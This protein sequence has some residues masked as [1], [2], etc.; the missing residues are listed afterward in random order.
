METKIQEADYLWCGNREAV[1]P[2]HLHYVEGPAAPICH[3]CPG[4]QGSAA[5][6]VTELVTALEALVEA[7]DEPGVPSWLTHAPFMDGLGCCFCGAEWR[8]PMIH[9]DCPIA[10]GEALLLRLKGG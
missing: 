1:H 3:I 8:E 6:T 10:A 2:A 5:G 4:T 7:E 9:I